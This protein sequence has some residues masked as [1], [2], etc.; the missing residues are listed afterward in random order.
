MKLRRQ[1]MGPLLALVLALLL[2]LI[3]PSATAADGVVHLYYF[4]DPGCA[5]CHQVHEEII[6]PLLK[7][8][9]SQLLI[10]ERDMSDQATFEYLLALESQFKVTEP[11]IPEVFIGTDALIGD[12]PIRAQLRERVEF[13]LGQGGVA[14]PEVAGQA[15]PT[16]V[17]T[18]PLAT[19]TPEPMLTP[20]PLPSSG[21]PIYLAWFY[22][23]GCDL[24]ARKEHDLSYLTALYPQV[25]AERFNGD[26]DTALFQYLCQRAGVPESKQLV[27]PSVF[28]GG[29]ALV[30]E[31]ISVRAMEALIQ[32]YLQTGSAEP[33]AGFEEGKHSA[34]QTI[35]ERFRSLGIL[36]VVG[37]GLIDGLNPC[38]FATMIFLISYLAVRKRRGVELLATGAA[39]TLG[40]FLAYLGLGLGMLKF[41]TTLPILSTIGKWIYGI[42]MLLCLALALGS[43][44]DYRKARE[45]RLEDMSLKLPDYLR[46]VQRRLIREGSRSSRFVL[47]SFGL[48]FVVS[49]VELACT[50]Q[51]YLP[52]IVFVLGLAEWRARATAALVVYNL[53]FVV[54]LIAVFLLVYFGTTSQQLTKWMQRHAAAIK[55]GMGLLFLLL[56][57]WLGYSIISV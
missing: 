8:Y 10:D 32:P 55:L 12:Q 41:L 21:Q 34:E 5:V 2:G 3:L 47:A 40:V 7:E 50:G 53:M 39:F 14:L 46:N 22:D 44:A 19:R 45:G 38:A 35:I 36:T 6:V 43:F 26:E 56:A 28:V 31:E 52:T 42:T 17:P 54:P 25:K 51:V 11:G 15:L 4:F 57:A 37:A 27:A 18:F 30:A 20:T 24:C 13:Y 49:V 48:G 9:G 29:Q 16:K 33:W 1:R 23:P